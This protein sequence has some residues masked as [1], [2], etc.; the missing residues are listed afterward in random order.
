MTVRITAALAAVLIAA[1]TLLPT[2]HNGA[3]APRQAAV[4]PLKSDRPLVALALGSGGARGFAHVGVIKAL[5]EAGIVPDI[6]TGSSSG[7][8]VAAL[9]ADGRGARELE[10][11]ALEVEPSDLVDFVLFGKGWVK[12]KA[13]QEFVNRMVDGKPIERLAKPFAVVATEAKSGRMTVF[14]RGGT[15]LAVRASAS[16]PNV[17][18][19]P[20]INGEEY[21][22]GGLSSPVPVK[23]ARA[24]GADIVIAVDVSWFAQ[25]RNADSAGAMAQHGRGGRYVLL[26]GELD[27]ADVV[28]APRTA[29]TRMLDFGQ[30]ETNIAAGEAAGREAVLQ[31]REMIARTAAA[32]QARLHTAGK[33]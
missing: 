9:Y 21:V 30:K 11:I 3:G 7:A 26:A 16:V 4:I 32:K 24:M 13:L 15:G 17:F 18:V 23:L 33:Q 12:G 19:S 5:E 31:L 20:V 25:A 28:I 6:V 8:V 29:R 22:D 14:N 2:N 1:C 10:R 27:A